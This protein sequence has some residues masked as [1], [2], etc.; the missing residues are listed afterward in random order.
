M[1]AIKKLNLNPV[2]GMSGEHKLETGDIPQSPR[3]RMDSVLETPRTAMGRKEAVTG[4]YGSVRAQAKRSSAQSAPRHARRL[5]DA[6]TP[7][8]A[9]PRT[10]LPQAAEL[11]GEGPVAIASTGDLHA[12]IGVNGKLAIWQ[13]KGVK[14]GDELQPLC[15]VILQLPPDIEAKVCDDGLGWPRMASDGLGVPPTPP[16]ACACLPPQAKKMD[17]DGKMKMLSEKPPK[18]MGFDCSGKHLGVHRPGVGFWLCQV[19]ADGQVRWL[20]L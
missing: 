7:T 4:Q 3:A 8:R 11:H 14:E 5:C 18:W 9:F 20:A 12:S 16:I 19:H 2:A 6:P 17:K 1:P 15:Q 10:R 13:A